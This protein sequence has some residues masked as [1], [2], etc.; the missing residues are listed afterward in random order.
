MSANL[1]ISVPGG[2]AFL[3][4]HSF[5]YSVFPK[6]LLDTEHCLL[7]TFLTIQRSLFLFLLFPLRLIIRKRSN[8]S[9]TSSLSTEL[10][11]TSLFA[12]ILIFL[13]SRFLSTIL[14]YSS[15]TASVISFVEEVCRF[16]LVVPCACFGILLP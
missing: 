13:I 3:K 10:S 1:F 7:H 14:S 8:C 16:R 6:L 5:Q 9:Y 11:S 4:I 15:I 12:V 2:C